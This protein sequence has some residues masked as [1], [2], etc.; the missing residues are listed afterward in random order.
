MLSMGGVFLKRNVLSAL[1]GFAAG[2]ANG[3][4]GA[5]GGMI[6]VPLLTGV[7]DLEDTEVFPASVA[8][9]LPICV[10]SL[11][12]TFYTT[13][14]TLNIIWPYIAGSAIGGVAAGIGSKKIP[15]KWLHRIL[16]LLIL[17]GGIRY[18]W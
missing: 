3:L 12:T 9:I 18:L 10:V 6:L 16:G 17:W 7:T 13:S 1:A 5:G 4:F 14:V 15:V 8:I 2:A 11:V